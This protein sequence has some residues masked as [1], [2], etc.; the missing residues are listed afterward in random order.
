MPLS[1]YAMSA[2]DALIAVMLVTSAASGEMRDSER[3]EIQSIVGLLPAFDGYD[4]TR[5]PALT[6]LT[7]RHLE[8]DDGLDSLVSLVRKA[9]PPH[10]FETAYALA[11]DVAA[12]DQKVDAPEMRFLEMLRHEFSIDRLNAAAIERGSRARHT[13][14]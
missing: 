10:L 14:L 11:C 7:L 13:R 1:G 6:D 9:L 4:A 2:Q 8:R 5:L 12:A 3:R